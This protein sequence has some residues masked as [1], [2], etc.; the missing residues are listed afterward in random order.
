[1][2]YKY[3]NG[4]DII[5]GNCIRVCLLPLS[6]QHDVVILVEKWCLMYIIRLCDLCYIVLYS[7]QDSRTLGGSADDA[8][9]K[10]KPGVL[11]SHQEFCHIMFVCFLS[12]NGAIAIVPIVITTTVNISV[13]LL[14]L[15]PRISKAK[16]GVLLVPKMSRP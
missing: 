14:K 15:F 8:R 9:G 11:T 5:D 4:K 2:R 10:I 12:I 3:S 7:N 6:P 16:L 13:N 1:M